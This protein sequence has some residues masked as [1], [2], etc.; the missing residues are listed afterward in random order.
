VCEKSEIRC[1]FGGNLRNYHGF[2]LRR[3]G[4]AEILGMARLARVSVLPPALPGTILPAVILILM[5]LALN[6]G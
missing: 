4:R 2:L 1:G 3:V 5:R 6:T